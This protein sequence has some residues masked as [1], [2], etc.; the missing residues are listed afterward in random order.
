MEYIKRKDSIKRAARE[1]FELKLLPLVRKYLRQDF[2]KKKWTFNEF[3]VGST[4]RNLVLVGNEGFDMDYQL[5]FDRMPE[6]Y[7]NDAKEMKE[8]FRGYF[9]KAIRELK[10]PLTYCEDSTHS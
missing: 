5:R 10:L 3:I 8:L 9:D 4:K 2:G 1:D 7:K 6:K